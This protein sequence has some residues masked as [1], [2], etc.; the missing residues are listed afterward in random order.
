MLLFE[1]V[2]LTDE[3]FMISSGSLATHKMVEIRWASKASHQTW[4]IFQTLF[5]AKQVIHGSCPTVK[6]VQILDVII[7]IISVDRYVVVKNMLPVVFPH[8]VCR[9]LRSD[10]CQPVFP[11]ENDLHLPYEESVLWCTCKNLKKSVP[12][13]PE[14]MRHLSGPLV[15]ID[16]LVLVSSMIETKGWLDCVTN[17]LT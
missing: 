2:F 9:P 12:S 15:P 16:I 14:E 5:A 4:M 3:N 17:L 7:I 6:F 1:I 10:W 11:G 8:P 13:S